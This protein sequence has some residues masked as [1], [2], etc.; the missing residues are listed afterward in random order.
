MGKYFEDR[1]LESLSVDIVI[2]DIEIQ[3]QRQ[4]YRE[5]YQN[6]ELTSHKNKEAEPIWPVQK[7]IYQ[8]DTYRKDL[9]WLDFYDGLIQAFTRGSKDGPTVLYTCFCNLYSIP[10]QQLDAPDQT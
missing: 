6:N 1:E 3:E 5:I 4:K 7:N 10:K 2:L 8:S 9:S